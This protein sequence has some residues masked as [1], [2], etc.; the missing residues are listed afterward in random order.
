MLR[1]LCGVITLLVRSHPSNIGTQNIHL[2]INVPIIDFI[3]IVCLLLAV[4]WPVSMYII[5]SD[6]THNRPT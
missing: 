6:D 2:V 4:I 1:Q 5:I 3:S